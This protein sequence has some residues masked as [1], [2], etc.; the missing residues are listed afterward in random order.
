MRKTDVPF[1]CNKRGSRIEVPQRMTDSI[2]ELDKK[3]GGKCMPNENAGVATTSK[4]PYRVSV[5]LHRISVQFNEPMDI[6]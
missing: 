6:E 2:I 1:L 3:F 4:A 5:R